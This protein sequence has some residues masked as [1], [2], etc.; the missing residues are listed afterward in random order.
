M[1]SQAWKAELQANLAL[2]ELEMDQ[3]QGLGLPQPSGARTSPA[4]DRAP[5]ASGL[6]H[7]LPATHV[8]K[9][10]PETRSQCRPAAD[11]QP[12]APTPARL[13]HPS[14]RSVISN[15]VFMTIAHRQQLNSAGG[16]KGGAGTA[17]AR[18]PG[19]PGSRAAGAAA[20]IL[21]GIIAAPR[22]LALEGHRE[23]DN[24]VSE[25]A[26]DPG[27]GDGDGDGDGPGPGPGPAPG[28]MARANQGAH[29]GSM[30]FRVLQMMEQKEPCADQ[31]AAPA[32][33]P[34]HWTN[35]SYMPQPQPQPQPQQ[36]SHHLHTHQQAVQ[37]LQGQGQ[38]QPAAQH[39]LSLAGRHDLMEV[40]PSSLAWHTAE[41]L[42]STTSPPAN[43]VNLDMELAKDVFLVRVSGPATG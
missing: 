40:A 37:S 6:F 39:G 1:L 27:A 2:A 26:A 33:P 43:V 4:S 23:H 11:T 17:V 21:A 18:P 30:M 32:A 12:I 31:A 19:V 36:A 42:S 29:V 3:D 10:A 14:T 38:G 24:E 16:I 35:P 15:N 8:S 25:A 22:S 9:S 34:Q 7:N 20:R 28:T 41:P 13:G 5:T